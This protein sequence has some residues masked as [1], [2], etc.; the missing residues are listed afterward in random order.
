MT[1]AK[2][3]K[4]I[5]AGSYNAGE[6]IEGDTLPVAVY[7][8]ATDNEFYACDGNDQAKLDFI[9]F[10]VSDG[11]DGGSI[12]IQFNGIVKGFTGL[13]EG[14]KYYVQNDKTIGTTRGTYELQVGIA[15]SA[16]ELLIQ[17]GSFQYIGSVSHATSISVLA[18]ARFAIIVSSA[19]GSASN[20]RYNVTFTI[21]KVGATT[22]SILSKN[23]SADIYSGIGASWS[24]DT[25][26]ITYTELA[27]S[28]SAVAYFYN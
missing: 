6:T 5:I 19:T 7:Q 11:T 2:L 23:T 17:K 14:T 12:D 20:V 21:A 26:T 16:T 22:G 8:K 9:G 10:A 3:N 15:I 1:S 25:I 4:N 18:G 24:G 27:D 13:T 28:R